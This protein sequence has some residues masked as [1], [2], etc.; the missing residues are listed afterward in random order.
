M[1][2]TYKVPLRIKISRGI[3]RVFFKVV[4][5]LLGK[6]ELFG[7]ENIPDNNRYVV[8]FNHVSL[9]EVPFIAAYWPTNL[10]II[11]AAAVW[12][13]SG[14]SLIAKM[15]SGIQ[16]KRTEFDREVFKQVELVYKA[17][18]PLMISP[19]GGRSHTPG[20]RRGKPGIAY[21]ID[22]IG[23]LEVVPVAVVGN[24]MDFLTQGLRLKRPTIQMI[25]GEPFRVPPLTGRGEQRREMRQHNTDLIMARLAALLP[26]SYRGVYRDYQRILAGEDVEFDPPPAA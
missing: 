7:L 11:G 10:E 8:A 16:V 5:S 18:R 25:V 19:E 13:R 9:V 20:L 2:E 24:T 12:E 26:E 3:L 15:W 1:E 17:D 14:Q 21:I 23:D 22:K 4:F 6:V